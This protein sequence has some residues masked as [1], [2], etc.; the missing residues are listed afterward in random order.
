MYLHVI[1]FQ[2]HGTFPSVRHSLPL[3]VEPLHINSVAFRDSIQP[4]LLQRMDLLVGDRKS[5]SILNEPL[6]YL[7]RCEFRRRLGDVRV[8][9]GILNGVVTKFLLKSQRFADASHQ[10]DL[11]RAKNAILTDKQ[12]HA[13]KIVAS[14][15][16]AD[17]HCILSSDKP[18]ATDARG[19][20]TQTTG[21]TMISVNPVQ[22]N[23]TIDTETFLDYIRLY[24][25]NGEPFM[26]SLAHVFKA[27]SDESRLRII[28][29]LLVSGELCV[30]DIERVMGFTQTKVSRHLAYL[31]RV[32]LIDGRRQGLWML[33]SIARP[34]TGEQEQ[35]L[36]FLADLLKSNDLAQRDAKRL[37]ANIR[38][39][40][41]STYSVVK[42]KPIPGILE[43][44]QN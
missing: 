32:G 24:E 25:Y 38:K 41:C 15:P 37:A 5:E 34:R 17:I 22:C 18:R 11:R 14:V 28:N 16:Y 3:V 21:E 39:G 40:C 44:Y 2:A 30:C 43:M 26:G 42:A 19:L 27:L 20:Q 9:E 31:R 23:V 35:L 12:E 4:L 8:L 29:L 10:L 33:Y 1:H 13:P 6:R 7:L 36:R